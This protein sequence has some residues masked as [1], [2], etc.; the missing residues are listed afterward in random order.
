MPTRTVSC[1]EVAQVLDIGTPE[2]AARMAEDLDLDT[3]RA[4]W[5]GLPSLTETDAA[6]LARA[7][8][9]MRRSSAEHSKFN[10]LANGQA[11]QFEKDTMEL[12]RHTFQQAMAGKRST[13]ALRRNAKEAALAAA[14][15]FEATADEETRRRIHPQFHGSWDEAK[16]GPV[17]KALNRL[18]GN[19]T[20]DVKDTVR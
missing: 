16:P 13:P 17:R 6:T 14:R 11:R 10:N 15:D 12:Y 1:A 8:A 4:H 18:A 5:S 19:D 20:P 2:R 9:E 7:V 3:S